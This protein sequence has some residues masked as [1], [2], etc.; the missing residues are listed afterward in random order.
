MRR[1]DDPTCVDGV[2]SSTH[3]QKRSRSPSGRGGIGRNGPSSMPSI[4]AACSRAIRKAPTI[5]VVDVV[6]DRQRNV[7]GVTPYADVGDRRIV[8]YP[9]E[10]R[11]GLDEPAVRLGLQ[12][13]EHLRAGPGHH[14]DPRR[15]PVQRERELRFLQDEQRADHLR[16]RRPAL[17][18]RSDDDVARAKLKAVPAVAVVDG[19][20]VAAHGHILAA[21]TGVC[22]AWLS[23]RPWQLR[24]ES[25]TR[26]H[27]G[28]RTATR[29]V[30]VR[31]MIGPTARTSAART[32]AC[33]CV[34]LSVRISRRPDLIAPARRLPTIRR[35]PVGSARRRGRGGRA[36]G[37]S[38]GDG[39]ATSG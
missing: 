13:R 24:R 20:L 3:C 36:S 18:R 17:R 16:P 21:S 14:V 22:A 34:V 39:C 1:S 23:W 30:S 31:R 26:C 9:V 15:E 38:C 2:S 27:G 29:V 32:A 5:R 33:P 11:V 8:G 10:R 37:A 35:P 7:A 28:P 12:V 4:A 25:A 6:V 19:P